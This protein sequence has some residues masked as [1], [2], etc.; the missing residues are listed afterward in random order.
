MLA[1]WAQE[2]EPF[3][4]GEVGRVFEHLKR[5]HRGSFAPGIGDVLYALAGAE[6]ERVSLDE[7]LTEL[8]RLSRHYHPDP[9]TGRFDPRLLSTFAFAYGPAAASWVHSVTVEHLLGDTH[10]PGS[11]SYRELDRS[12]E[13]WY[14]RGPEAAARREG[15]LGRISPEP[16]ARAVAREYSDKPAELP[17]AIIIDP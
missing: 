7:I 8:R 11:H 2:L 17:G 16:P 10:S 12:L 1:V 13:R 9:V 4:A 5:T 14:E 3:P 6:R 15:T